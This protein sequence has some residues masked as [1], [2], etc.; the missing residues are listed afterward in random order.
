MVD[1]LLSLA[2]GLGLAAAC[3]FRVFVP[4]LALSFGA[5]AGYVPLTDGFAWI[6]SDGALVAFAV[7]TV[8]EVVAYYVPWLDHLLDVAASPA[9]IVAGM[10]TS[11]SVIGD[12]PPLLKWTSVVIGGGGI[13]ALVQGST[14]ALRLGSTAHTGGLGNA[15]VAT[16][17]LFGAVLTSVLAVVLPLLAAAVALLC[18]W[19]IYRATRRLRRRPSIPI[20]S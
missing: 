9:A 6:G 11:A 4:L 15:F 5:R 16:A 20:P 12:L 2:A 7:A 3:G 19:L 1:T 8:L 17:E 14:V 10:L 13:A 18:G